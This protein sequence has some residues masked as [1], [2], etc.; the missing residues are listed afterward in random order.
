MTEH[1]RQH[2]IPSSY[3]KAWCDPST[4]SGQTPYVWRF[5]K[6]GNQNNKEVPQKIFYETDMYTIYTQDGER[7]LTLEYN[8]SR[9]E[10][11]FS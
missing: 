4:P 3:L 11:E 9:V 6:D 2:Y 7:D 1:K 8:L 10:G 5:S